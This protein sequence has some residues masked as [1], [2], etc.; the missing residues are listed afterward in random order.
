MDTHFHIY[1]E[2]FCKHAHH[3]LLVI[4]LIIKILVIMILQVFFHL[5]KLLGKSNLTPVEGLSWSLYRSSRENGGDDIE[6][7]AECHSKLRVALDILHECFVDIIEPR[8]KSDLVA[9]LLFNRKWVYYTIYFLSS[10][11]LV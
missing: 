2:N 10:F 4:C 6:S 8:T 1:E 9:D 3:V 11:F 5:Q 7:I